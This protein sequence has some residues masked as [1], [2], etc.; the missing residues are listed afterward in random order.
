MKL[1]Q[2]DAADHARAEEVHV[3]VCGGP[4]DGTR[5]VLDVVRDGPKEIRVL[6]QGFAWTQPVVWASQVER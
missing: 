6:E 2:R 1:I 3:E 5:M 4:W